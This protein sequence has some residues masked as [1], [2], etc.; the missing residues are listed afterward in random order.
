MQMH[1][2]FGELKATARKSLEG[3]YGR[4]IS[5]LINV[6][7]LSFVPTYIILLFFSGNSIFHIIGAEIVGII[8]SAFLQV[9]QLGVSFFYLKLNCKQ[10]ASTVD[11]FHGFRS[12]RNPALGIGI[13]F[14]LISYICML[15]ATLC[16]Y[17]ST[18][19]MLAYLL[20]LAGTLVE[21]LIIPPLSQS[22]YILLDFPNYTVKQALALSIRIMK[23]NYFRYLLF[24]LSFIPLILI[25]FLC[26]G[27][28]LLWVLPYMECSLAAF[29]LDIMRSYRAKE[30]N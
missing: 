29:Y 4:A 1:Q 25:S 10:S 27:I 23:G 14:T 6:Q 8:L 30:S 11:I 26:C 17:L 19:I 12:N 20:L 24:L 28:G 13:V 5:V 15:P 9:L 16:T 18:D 2:S 22:Y 3:N 7:I 21:Y